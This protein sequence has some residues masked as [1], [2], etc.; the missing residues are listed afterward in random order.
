MIEDFLFIDDFGA[1]EEELENLP[2]LTLFLAEDLMVRDVIAIEAD[3]SL[4]KAPALMHRHSIRHLPVVEDGKLIG[5]ITRS[6]ILKALIE[7]NK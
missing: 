1:L 6:D 7:N 5:I 4:L 3:A 2:E